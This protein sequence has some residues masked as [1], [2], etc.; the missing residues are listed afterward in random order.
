MWLSLVERLVWDQDAAGSN[1]VIPTISSVH[2]GFKSE[3]STRFLYQYFSYVRAGSDEPA[4]FVMPE[5]TRL[6]RPVAYPFLSVAALEI[7]AV[8]PRRQSGNGL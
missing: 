2:N 1:P 8:P 7:P 6:P 4:R 3:M 5:Y